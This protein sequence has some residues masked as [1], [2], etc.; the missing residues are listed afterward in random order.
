M[1]YKGPSEAICMENGELVDL[2]DEP[3][4]KGV[5]F[6]KMEN[7]WT[8]K[9]MS[10]TLAILWWFEDLCPYSKHGHHPCT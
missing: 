9:I 8:N 2:C 1:K 7:S 10:S 3:F 5:L 6:E 4:N